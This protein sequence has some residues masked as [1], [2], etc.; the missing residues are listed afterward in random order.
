MRET[1]EGEGEEAAEGE[2]EEAAEGDGE[3]AAEGEGEETAEGEGEEAA[4]GEGEE[5]AEGDGEEAAEGEGEEA[6]EGDGEE[7]VEG[8]G[9]A[10]AEGEGEE[11]AEGEGEEAAE[12][13]GEEAAEGEGEEAAEGGGEEA[14]EGEGEEAAEGEGEEAAEGEGEEAAEGEGEEAAEGEGE[15]AA[16]GE[17]EEAAEGEGEEAAE[18]EGE[19]AAEG[20]GSAEEPVPAEPAPAE[21]APQSGGTTSPGTGVTTPSPTPQPTQV[22]KKI[23]FEEFFSGVFTSPQKHFYQGDK[24]KVRVGMQNPAA[25][26]SSVGVI[27]ADPGVFRPNPFMGDQEAYPVKIFANSKTA[28]VEVEVFGA[29]A[30]AK[31]VSLTLTTTTAGFA[32]AGKVTVPVQL[33]PYPT[34]HFDV[35]EP[36]RRTD[37]KKKITLP[38]GPSAPPPSFTVTEKAIL[39]ICLDD[40]PP[41]VGAGVNITSTSQVFNATINKDPAV[42]NRMYSAEFKNEDKLAEVPVELCQPGTA[43]IT[44]AVVATSRCQLAPLN[45]S[46]TL[47][48]KDGALNFGENWINPPGPYAVG[49]QVWIRVTRQIKPLPKPKTPPPPPPPTPFPP[50]NYVGKL[51]GP[52]VEQTTAK[53]PHPLDAGSSNPQQTAQA[54]QPKDPPADY[55]LLFEK[56][57]TE[58]KPVCVTAT[59]PARPGNGGGI[60]L[61]KASPPPGTLKKIKAVTKKEKT[62]ETLLVKIAALKPVDIPSPAPAS[63]LFPA[64][65]AYSPGGQSQKEIVVY[66]RRLLHFD[67][68]FLKEEHVYAFGDTLKLMV[69]LSVPARPN[70]KFKIVSQAFKPADPDKEVVCKSEYIADFPAGS[71][72]CAVLV[73]L[74]AEPPALTKE[75]FDCDIQLVPL[76]GN[77][78]APSEHGDAEKDQLPISLKFPRIGFDETEP[79]KPPVKKEEGVAAVCGEGAKLTLKVTL[80]SP[81]LPGTK[82]KIVA[83][84]FA[85]ETY[86]VAF[87]KD[88]TAKKVEVEMKRGDHYKPMTIII[89]PEALCVADDSADPDI[90]S[91]RLKVFVKRLPQIS[92]PISDEEKTKEDA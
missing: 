45:T 1:A 72:I 9:E 23:H 88:E 78:A 56:E 76:T 35:K 39:R 18:G 47:I 59:S 69:R 10:A 31:T 61:L 8:E 26:D 55:A 24:F 16:E 51:M 7:A 71:S 91:N 36:L 44:L 20:E 22:A 84:A 62:A 32:A 6:A 63:N 68:A 81:A 82:A 43:V 52:A 92:F 33:K 13:E 75:T 12:G 80:S 86:D 64:S 41:Q 87:E 85:N 2:G 48:V 14:A 42:P 19:E 27:K 65:A 29:V 11:A 34:V 90:G 15:E 70:T 74:D 77:I 4:E 38:F 89:I 49:D 30:A 66:P 57:K 17:G 53:D 5:A 46:V 3:E 58:S 50:A 73:K 40:L 60:R 21:P 67:P 79:V 54:N 28:D 83:Y 37:A 25:E